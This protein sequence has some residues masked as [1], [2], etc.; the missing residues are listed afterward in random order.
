MA[1]MMDA[2][3]KNIAKIANL[4]NRM[5]PSPLLGSNDWE[6]SPSFSW[7]FKYQMVGIRFDIN[8][9]SNQLESR[10]NR[11]NNSQFS[12]FNSQFHPST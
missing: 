3:A 7:Y 9:L 1:G 6:P 11:T 10:R 2:I 8:E 5:A 4:S 12:V